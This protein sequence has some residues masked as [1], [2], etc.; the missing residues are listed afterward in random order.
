[1]AVVSLINGAS[2]DPEL[3]HTLHSIL[4]QKKIAKGQGALSPVPRVKQGLY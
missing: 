3:L 2:D 4:E 1:M